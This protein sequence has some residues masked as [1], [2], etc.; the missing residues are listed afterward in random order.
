MATAR[1][2][3]ISCVTRLLCCSLWITSPDLR[4]M[5]AAGGGIVAAGG[6]SQQAMSLLSLLLPTS[7]PASIVR[8]LTCRLLTCPQGNNRR[9]DMPLQTHATEPYTTAAGA[10]DPYA[11]LGARPGETNEATL[12]AAYKERSRAC[13]PDAGGSEEAFSL[14]GAAYEE[15]LRRSP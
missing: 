11:V 9:D 2:P 1:W 13:H 7:R 3:K 10:V 5:M 14:V 15:L 12:K 6:G 8:E 4:D